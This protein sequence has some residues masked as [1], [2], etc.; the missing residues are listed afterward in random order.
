MERLTTKLVEDKVYALLGIFEVEVVIQY[1]QGWASAMETMKEAI[2]VQTN[3]MRD[4]RITHPKDDKARIE[5]DKGGLLA[6]VC[7]WIFDYPELQR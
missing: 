4:L 3:V 7:D 1:G 5:Q 6:G 2:N